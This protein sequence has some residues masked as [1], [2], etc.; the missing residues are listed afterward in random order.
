MTTCRHIRMHS[1]EMPDYSAR[2]CVDCRH[3]WESI[4]EPGAP[5]DGSGYAKVYL[6]PKPRASARKERG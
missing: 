5:D 3:Q 1:F 4:P 6:E 2:I